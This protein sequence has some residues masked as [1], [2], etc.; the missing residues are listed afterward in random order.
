M[1][2][3][4]HTAPV[5]PAVHGFGNSLLF[6]DVERLLKHDDA[7]LTAGVADLGDV[8]RMDSAG[9]ALLLELTRR[10]HQRGA[11][12][13]IRGLDPRLRA[14]LHFFNVDEL[15]DLDASPPA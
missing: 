12:L 10:A 7:L 1:S 9:I 8:Q 11:R 2:P 6:G 15:L 13:R 14:L 4:G 5:T 3:T